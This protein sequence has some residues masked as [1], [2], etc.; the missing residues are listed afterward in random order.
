MTA[1]LQVS[2]DRVVSPPERFIKVS[3]DRLLEH[4]QGAGGA[5]RG[6]LRGAGR[7]GRGGVGGAGAGRRGAGQGSCSC[8]CEACR[9][10][11][12][13]AQHTSPL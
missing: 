13:D 5:G 9:T 11:E 1:A 10:M 8:L 6:G 3:D 2:R 4:F 7:A 12:K